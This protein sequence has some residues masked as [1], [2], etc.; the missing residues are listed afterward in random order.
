[1][2]MEPMAFAVAG[3]LGHSDAL[4]QIARQGR[5]LLSLYQQLRQEILTNR[6]LFPPSTP[7]PPDLQPQP[8]LELQKKPVET[9]LT[10]DQEPSNQSTQNECVETMPVETNLTESVAPQPAKPAQTGESEANASISTD[11]DNLRISERG[12]DTKVGVLRDSI[13]S[14]ET[15]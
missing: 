5:R 7:E 3:L 1:M 14:T 11:T 12:K 13:L 8:D 6:E 2:L 9:K 10:E 15:S 4:N